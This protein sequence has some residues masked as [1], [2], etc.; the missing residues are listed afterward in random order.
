MH[1]NTLQSRSL[2]CNVGYYGTININTPSKHKTFVLHLYNAGPTSSTLAQHGINAIGYKCFV[3]AEQY[4][5]RS[6]MHRITMPLHVKKCNR[7][8]T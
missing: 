4:I 3:L 5:I 2:K 8:H 1:I 6:P 7:H